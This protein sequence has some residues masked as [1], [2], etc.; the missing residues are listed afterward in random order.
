MRIDS[1]SA[2]ITAGI[3]L[4]NPDI[5]RLRQNIEAIVSQVQDLVIVDN[6]SGN[7][8][9][10]DALVKIYPNVTLILSEKNLG[11]AY[12]QNRICQ[13]AE[14]KGYDWAITLDQDSISPIGLVDEYEKLI[15]DPSV[16]MVSPRIIDRNFGEIYIKENVSE[17]EEINEC[18]AS[19]SAIRISAWKEV[20]GFYEPLFIDKVDF[21]ICQSLREAGYIILR[22]NRV[23]L[24]HEVG[25]S[26]IVHYAGKDW[27]LLNHSPLRYYYIIRN[28]FIVG[29][30]HGGLARYILRD[31][32]VFY[33][34]TR[35]EDNKLEKAKKMLLG[36]IHGLIGKEGKYGK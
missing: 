12:A 34:V 29:R 35:F 22:T 13:F 15:N 18:I 24:L 4:Y 6:G 1:V 3:V 14:E 23:K 21:D 7:I 20:G 28:A 16:G 2:N 5:T 11:I 32:R 26:C 30:R 19:A 25:H 27:Q 9:E 36:F 17:V 8:C 33:Q 10:I 31:M